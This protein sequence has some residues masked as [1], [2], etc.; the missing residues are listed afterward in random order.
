RPGV[1]RAGV[2]RLDA[3]QLLG[4]PD[5]LGGLRSAAC[6]LDTVR[7]RRCGRVL[8]RGGRADLAHGAIEQASLTPGWH[9]GCPTASDGRAAARPPTTACRHE[10]PL[11][12]DTGAPAGRARA[13]TPRPIHAPPVVALL[14]RLPHRLRNPGSGRA[15]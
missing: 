5:R 1:V 4:D 10:D 3:P 6:D 7:A 2:R 9:A 8:A 12:V 14:G 15:P 11:V 13:P